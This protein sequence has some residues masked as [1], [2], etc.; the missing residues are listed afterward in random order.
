MSTPNSGATQAFGRSAALPVMRQGL[1]MAALLASVSA[2]ASS[3]GAAGSASPLFG[4]PKMP[5][6]A[7]DVITDFRDAPPA[8]AGDSA[9]WWARFADPVLDA[10]VREAL[11]E[12]ISVQQANSRLVQA[13]STGRA[14]VAGYAPR[15]TATASSDSNFAIDGTKLT[16]VTGGEEDSQTTGALGARVTWE[17]PLFGR[18]G[19]AISGAKA[20]VK[21][22]QLDVEAAKIAVIGDIAAGYVDLRNAQ[23]NLAYV[24]DDLARTEA[25][26]AIA[27]KRG[28]AGLLS[29]V[30]VSLA[31]T[32]AASVRARLP[33][34][35]LAV[36][37]G[38]DRL[39]ILRGVMPG[40]LDGR[41]APIAGFAFQNGAPALDAVP[42]N[43]VRR[44]LDVARAE[45]SA[46]LA[47]AQVG[48]SR[49]E[50]YPSLSL[51]G[52]ITSLASLAGS[53]LTGNLVRASA[54]PAI[55]LPLFDFGQRRAAL[56]S[57]QAQF[58][59]ALLQYRATTLN[60]VAEGQ[61]AL[62]A[63]DQARTRALA[64]ADSERAA[65]TRLNATKA[66]YQAGLV[67][68][69][70]LLDAQ[71]D[72]S[73]ARQSSLSSQAQFSNAAIGLYRTFAGAPGI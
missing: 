35:T 10:L 32:Q 39:A 52:S 56:A 53:V 55:N 71:R 15:L 49:S 61:S 14:T 44:R 45:Q 48:I 41:L 62:T 69:K 26:L 7:N 11:N 36:R 28:D 38:L 46:V 34:A 54:T 43:F 25:L 19:S 59:Q 20:G 66:A 18:L 70:D 40:S 8:P 30:D 23:L 9:A 24:Q 57:S 33:D 72:H 6:Q 17:V 60:A 58:Q 16:N 27:K 68:F 64:A 50:L 3:G 47:G 73:S 5:A 21:G 51:T 4:S 1:A 29:R 37:A 42:A 22:A 13:R 2:C 12:S 67:A 63:Y 65:T 31:Q